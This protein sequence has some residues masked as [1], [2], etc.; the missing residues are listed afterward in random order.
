MDVGHQ[1]Q[2]DPVDPWSVAEKKA[3]ASNGGL[4][5]DVTYGL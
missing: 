1:Q 3:K 2:I 4:D 5:D